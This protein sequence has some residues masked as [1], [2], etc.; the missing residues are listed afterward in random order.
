MVY[1]EK[2]TDGAQSGRSQCSGWEPPGRWICGIQ[3]SYHSSF[4]SIWEYDRAIRAKEIDWHPIVGEECPLCGGKGCW[5]EIGPYEREVIELFPFG[6]GKV[7]VARFLCRQGKGTFSLLP[8]QLAPYHRYTIESMVLAVLLWRQVYS[9]EGVVGA[10][11]KELSGDSEVTPWL[12][13]HWLGVL[14]AGLRLAHPVLQRWYDLDDIRSARGRDGLL[15]EVHA[16][17]VVF[18]SRDPP[19]RECLP[20]V[21]GRYSAATGRHLVGKPSQER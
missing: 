19:L 7:L 18:G 2:L 12:L 17:F 20:E 8:C 13:R 6:R 14:V 10:V 1:L 11:E 15:D 3:L 9:E 4:P 21:L 5:R 16:Y